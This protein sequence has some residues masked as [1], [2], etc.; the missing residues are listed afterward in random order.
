MAEL[1]SVRREFE[2]R[3]VNPALLARLYGEYADVGNVETFITRAVDSFPSGNC[4]VASVYLRHKFGG[5]ILHCRYG[6]HNHT[7]LAF[8]SEIVDITADQ[9]GGPPIYIGPF[10]KPWGSV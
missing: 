2:K 3:T 1:E 8:G 4:G 10:Q 5:E 7:V 9:Y 6:G